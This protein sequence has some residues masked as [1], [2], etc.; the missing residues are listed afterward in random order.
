M[1]GNMISS[2]QPAA[3]KALMASTTSSRLFIAPEITC[4]AYSP[5]KP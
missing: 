1:H 2:S 3:L 4:L 5:L